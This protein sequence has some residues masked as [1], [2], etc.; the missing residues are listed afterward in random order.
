MSQTYPVAFLSREAIIQSLKDPVDSEDVIPFTIAAFADSMDLD[1][2]GDQGPDARS[3]ERNEV[4]IPPFP[5]LWTHGLVNTKMLPEALPEDGPRWDAF[6]YFSGLFNHL[7][8]LNRSGYPSAMVYET[9]ADLEI[10]LREDPVAR[11]T[12]VSTF[13]WYCSSFA[14]I[15]MHDVGFADEED[16]EE[17][18]TTQLHYKL[19]VY[20]IRL[21][22]MPGSVLQGPLPASYQASHDALPEQFRIMVD[23]IH[24]TACHDS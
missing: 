21:P 10:W 16:V 13:L 5:Y 15:E 17:D 7:A 12:I 19:G 3:E 24:S 22:Y 18:G 8:R 23:N 6:G 11:A 2:L 20:D 1:S 14:L 4:K 9:L